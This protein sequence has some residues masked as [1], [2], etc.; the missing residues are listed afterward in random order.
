MPRPTCCLTPLSNA[1]R[2]RVMMV[3]VA[4]D[5]ERHGMYVCV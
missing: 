1:T 5:G 4:Q 3:P 2:L